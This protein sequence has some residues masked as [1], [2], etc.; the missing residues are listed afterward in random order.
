MAQ[1]GMG[2]GM[3]LHLAMGWVYA[4]FYLVVSIVS[5]LYID[6]ETL[7]IFMRSVYGIPY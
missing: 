7:K 2:F 4:S 6:N 1:Y 3:G 5:I